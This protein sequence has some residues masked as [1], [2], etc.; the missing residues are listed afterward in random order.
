MEPNPKLQVEQKKIIMRK[1][2]MISDVHEQWMKLKIPSCDLLIVAGDITYVGDYAKIQE[3]NNWAFKLQNKGHVGDVL[4]IAGNH[5]LTAQRDP[6]TWKALLPDV[7]YIEDEEVT[8]LGL[9]I[10]GSPWTPSFFKES[11]VFNADRGEQIKQYW[12]K[13]PAGLDILITHGPAYG[14][15]D[16]TPRGERVGCYDL[17]EAILDKKPRVHVC[18]HIHH[19]AGISM[20]GNTVCVN[21]A[22]CTEAYKATN[23]PI[24]IEL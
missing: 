3:F 10:Y 17:R 18:G 23:M 15:G 7:T 19:A 5:D 11:W 22:S 1:I 14:Q 9:R 6:E 8:R 24:M 2:C 4:L 12:D 16:L 13:I 21:A 20:L